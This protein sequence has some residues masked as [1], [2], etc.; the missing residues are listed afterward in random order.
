MDSM[1]SIKDQNKISLQ[2]PFK[3]TGGPCFTLKKID[4]GFD[5]T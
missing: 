2:P 1:F 3:T 5:V 4:I